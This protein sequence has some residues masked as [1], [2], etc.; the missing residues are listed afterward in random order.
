MRISE[1]RWREAQRKE[2]DFWAK[3]VFDAQMLRIKNRYR[4]SVNQLD[5][6]IDSGA[7][8]LE[9]GSGPTCLGQFFGKRHKVYLDPLMDSYRHHYSKILPEDGLLMKGVGEKLPFKN[10]CFRAVLSVNALDH[11]HDPRKVLDEMFRVLKSGGYLLIGIFTHHPF[12]ALLRGFA[13]RSVIFREVAHPHS[14]SK[15]GVLKL[16]YKKGFKVVSQNCVHGRESIF[17][18]HRRDHVI[19]CQK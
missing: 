14:F 16:L 4:D 11:M 6:F 8:I 17:S 15:I 1:N 5:E 9:V 18:F 2:A 10:S 7:T 19:I 13:E 3:G 12:L